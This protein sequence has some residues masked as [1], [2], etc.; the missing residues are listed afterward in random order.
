MLLDES[1]GVF[2]RDL[3]V[4]ND[5]LHLRVGMRGN[6]PK[7]MSREEVAIQAGLSVSYVQKIEQGTKSNV[8]SAS[9]AHLLAALGANEAQRQYAYSLAGLPPAPSETAPSTDSFLSDKTRAYVDYLVPHLAGYVD[10]AWNV[11]YANSEYNRIF[12]GIEE[13]GNVLV[14]LLE[15][16]RAKTVMV[17]WEAETQLTV[18]W[19]RSLSVL[20]EI[21]PY[22]QKLEDRLKNNADFWR[23]L[24]VQDPSVGRPKP[25][26][27]IRDLATGDEFD[28]HVELWTPPQMSA[29]MQ[30]YLG[31]R[32]WP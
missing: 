5:R 17:E 12:E 11:L 6:R 9:L 3:R 15:D 18:S 29:G 27:R 21:K 8:T 32:R 26:Q 23:M 7:G 1:L 28:L 13:A 4:N 31:V 30:M 10:L 16:E 24:K 19:A 20:P 25:F 2:I 14:W 22:Y